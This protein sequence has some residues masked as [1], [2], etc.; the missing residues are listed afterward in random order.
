MSILTFGW[1]FSYACTAGTRVESTHTVSGPEVCAAALKPSVVPL[2]DVADELPLP[3]AATVTATTATPTANAVRVHDALGRL[4]ARAA[5]VTRAI[6]TST[7]LCSRPSRL[8]DAGQPRSP[9]C[10]GPIYGAHSR[11]RR[12]EPTSWPAETIPMNHYDVHVACIIKAH[13]KP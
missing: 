6:D 11:T 10:V 2:P 9:K 8:R 7:T 4:R 12:A 13:G 3:H 5:L 1:A